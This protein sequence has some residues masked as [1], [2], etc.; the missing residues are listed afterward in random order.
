[1]TPAPT[2]SGIPERAVEEAGACAVCPH[3]LVAHDAISMRFCHATQ[4]AAAT[5]GCVC[6]SS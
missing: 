2:V 1:M 3:A 5:R 6:R 4:A